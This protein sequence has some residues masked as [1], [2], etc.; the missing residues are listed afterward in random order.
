MLEA[1]AQLLGSMTPMPKRLSGWVT[2]T[3]RS[4]KPGKHAG[5]PPTVGE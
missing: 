2:R 3:F 5:E 4:R 1:L